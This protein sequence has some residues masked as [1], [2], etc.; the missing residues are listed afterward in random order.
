[1]DAKNIIEDLNLLKLSIQILAIAGG[2]GVQATKP[3]DTIIDH[4]IQYIEKTAEQKHE[5]YKYC[6]NCG[7]K[8]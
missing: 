5:G 7:T 2:E 4:A 3:I 6:P 1:M 8:I